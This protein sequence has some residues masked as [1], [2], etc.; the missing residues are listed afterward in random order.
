MRPTPSPSQ[1]VNPAARLRHAWWEAL[2]ATALLASVLSTCGPSDAD[3][4]DAPATASTSTIA[5]GVQ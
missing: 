1:T 2:A 3:P 4:G 5:P